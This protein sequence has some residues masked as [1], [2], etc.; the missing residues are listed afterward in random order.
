VNVITIRFYFLE[1]HTKLHHSLTVATV[2][3]T[4][5]TQEPAFSHMARAQSHYT[6]TPPVYATNIF[7]KIQQNLILCMEE[8]II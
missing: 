6:D 7:W 2:T 1:L 3:S 8:L 4:K 5:L